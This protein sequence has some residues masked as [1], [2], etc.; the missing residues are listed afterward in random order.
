MDLRLLLDLF[1]FVKCINWYLSGAE[2]AT[3]L[4]A[5]LTHL[6]CAKESLQQ[7]YSADLPHVI[8][9]VSST[10]PNPIVLPWTSSNPSRRSAV[11]KKNR[12]GDSVDPWGLLVSV[13]IHWLV[14]LIL[15]CLSVG[16]DLMYSS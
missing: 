11:K 9:F 3:N 16:K 1:F 12:I 6:S 2:V 4:F 8:R 13:L 7:L 15:I 10:K 5:L 14:R